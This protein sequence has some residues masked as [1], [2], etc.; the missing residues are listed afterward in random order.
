MWWWQRWQ[1]EET[2]WVFEYVEVLWWLWF[3]V[4]PRRAAHLRKVIRIIIIIMCRCRCDERKKFLCNF[5]WLWHIW[6]LDVWKWNGKR[7][8]SSWKYA[9]I[10]WSVLL[11]RHLLYFK[12]FFHTLLQLIQQYFNIFFIFYFKHVHYFKI[13]T[14]VVPNYYKLSRVNWNGRI[15]IT[16]KTLT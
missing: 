10:I 15:L 12:I 2:L 8:R 3:S 5:C 14:Y 11:K 13:N 4:A 6:T 7:L 1:I 16:F 9:R